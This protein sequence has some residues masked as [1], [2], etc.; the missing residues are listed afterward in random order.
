MLKELGWAAEGGVET[1]DDE[2]RRIIPPKSLVSTA[3]RCYRIVSSIDKSIRQPGPPESDPKI[4]SLPKVSAKQADP[5]RNKPVPPGRYS[6]KP[7]HALPPLRLSNTSPTYSDDNFIRNWVNL[8]PASQRSPSFVPND[9]VP[10]A[11]PFD[12]SVR[13]ENPEASVSDRAWQDWASLL[14]TGYLSNL[15]VSEA[16]EPGGVGGLTVESDSLNLTAGAGGATYSG[17]SGSMLENIWAS[18][19]DDRGEGLGAPKP[20]A[21]ADGIRPE[22]ASAKDDAPAMTAPA[23]AA[24]AIAET[25]ESEEHS[26]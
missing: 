13:Q 21:P 16:D 10:P 2:R 15:G 25:M 11:V 3:R 18:T 7:D 9:F 23:A 20:V 4:E 1:A 19:G 14:G 8:M 6:R 17:T 5:Y 12:M 22:G 24:G 26:A